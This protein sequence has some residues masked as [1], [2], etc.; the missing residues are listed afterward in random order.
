M[1]LCRVK[2]IIYGP[3]RVNPGDFG[4]PQTITLVPLLQFCHRVLFLGEIYQ[5]WF[6]VLQWHV[7]DIQTSHKIKYNNDLGETLALTISQKY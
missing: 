1:L 4:D 7:T 5:E 6:D 2:Y 3:W